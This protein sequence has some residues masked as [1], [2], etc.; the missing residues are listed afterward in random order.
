MNIYKLERDWEEANWE[1]DVGMVIAAYSPH[2]ARRTAMLHHATESPQV[3]RSSRVTL[4]GYTNKWRNSHV[5]MCS[6]KGA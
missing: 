2:E 6:N 3:W 1:E 4:I 5:I